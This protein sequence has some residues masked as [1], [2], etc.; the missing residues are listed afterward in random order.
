MELTSYLLKEVFTPKGVQAGVTNIKLSY[1]EQCQF[2][3]SHHENDEGSL[4]QLYPETFSAAAVKAAH[5]QTS[6]E[7]GR[8]I[9]CMEILKNQVHWYSE[10]NHNFFAAMGYEEA[11]LTGK[12][13]VYFENLS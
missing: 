3:G 11:Q 12:K 5:P 10:E 8:F 6:T 2:L 7:Y 13:Y 4:A 9:T 1:E